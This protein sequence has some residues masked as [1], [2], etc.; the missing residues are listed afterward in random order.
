MMNL[1]FL[2]NVTQ[3]LAA[4]VE[5]AKLQVNKNTPVFTIINPVTIP[6]EKSNFLENIFYCL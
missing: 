3:Q 6:Y 2:K 5:Q 1:I 4:Q